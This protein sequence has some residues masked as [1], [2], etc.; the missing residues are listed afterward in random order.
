MAVTDTDVEL[1]YTN[2]VA[3]TPIDVGIPTDSLSWIE[4]RYGDA[5]LLAVSG[6]DYTTAY[7]DPVTPNTSHFFVTPTASLITKIAADGP[8][9][10]YVR[11]HLPY[12]SA[13]DATNAAQRAD[14]VTEF[15]QTLYRIQQIAFL[16]SQAIDSAAD[17]DSAV[18]LAQ[19]AQTNAEAAETAAAASAAA[20]AASQTA[21]AASASSA[22]TSAT[23]AAASA[24]AAA[25]SA[26][27]A[28]TSATNAAASATSASAS[29]TTATTQAT[30]ASNSATSASASATTATTQATNASNSATAAATSA[31]NAATSATNAAASATA[32]ANSAAT[33]TYATTTETLTGTAAN[34]IVSPDGLAALWEKGSNVAAAA[35]VVLGEGG[36]FHITGTGGPV[37]DIDFGTAKDGRFALLII[38]ST[39]TFTHGSTLKISGGENWAP[40][41]DDM[42]LVYQ[43]NGDTVYLIPLPRTK[44]YQ[45]IDIVRFTATNAS[46]APPAR[47]KAAL[48]RGVGGG[49]GGGGADTNGSNTGCAS[50][51]GGGGYAE[52]WETTLSTSYNVQIGAGGGGGSAGNNAGSAGGTTSVTGGATVISVGGGAGGAG[53]GA[54][55]ASDIITNST[56]GG[57]V[58]TGGDRSHGGIPGAGGIK[59]NDS[60]R[61]AGSGGGSPFGNG[62]RGSGT[63]SG[64]TG[65]GGAAATGYGAGG[66]GGLAGTGADVA[67]GDGSDGYVEC[68]LYTLG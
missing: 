48:W 2:V 4:V 49:G 7:D 16:A 18:A 13:F 15:N 55:S 17:L 42:A 6:V 57:S 20:A 12:T 62:G 60:R 9:A 66:S 40:T 64:G 22:S 41:A 53:S 36:L 50:G 3:S 52:K 38:D 47:A 43:D 59:I 45:L 35:T 23:N 46:Y 31:T 26:S 54:A 34:R 28:S 67:G 19:T 58:N 24:S 65:T 32:A 29:A 61:L 11:R 68:W 21:A 39:P 14:V 25:T 56:S 1:S 33:L 44:Q 27:S 37:T 8:N 30:N 63:S 10:I 51:G 5:K